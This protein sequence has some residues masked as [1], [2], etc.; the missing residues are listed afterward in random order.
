MTFKVLSYNILLG[1]EDRLQRIADIIRREEPDAVALLEANDR[2]NVTT[3]AHDLGMQLVFGEA[4]TEFHIAWLSR[5]PIHRWENHRLAALSKTLLEIEV[6]WAGLPVGLFATHLGSRHDRFRPEDEVPVIL[7]VL[8][9]LADAPHLLVGDF[10]ALHPNDAVGT[11]PN[12]QEK[13]GEA[14]E[15]VPRKAIQLMLEAGYVDCYHMLHPRQ[16]GYTYPS[17]APWLRLDYVFASSRLARHLTACDSITG[18]AAEKASDHCP[19]W[20]AFS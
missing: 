3:L 2:A 10:N 12:G 14:N 11:P 4:N 6:R 19:V 18:T 7:D 17:H 9:S 15:G 1:G 8:R 5:L 16:P 20:V 13:R